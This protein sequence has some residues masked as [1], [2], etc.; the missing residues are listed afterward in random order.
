MATA[1]ATERITAKRAAQRERIIGAAL[2]AFSAR[3]FEATTT[4]QIADA[5]QMTGPALYHYFAA[6]DELLLACVTHLLDLLLAAL[7]QAAAGPGSPADRLAQ[8]VRVQIGLELRHG[9]AAPLVNAHLYGP[10]YLTDLLSPAQQTLLRDQQRALVQV[11]RGLID[12]GLACGQLA[13]AQPG[14]AAFNVLAVVQY[15]SVW[16]RPRAGRQRQDLIEQ[17]A[18]AVLQMLGCTAPPLPAARPPSRKGKP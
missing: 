13:T 3:G 2:Q 12:E 6:K 1:M 18:A 14:I 15:T 7:T 9:A 11:Y 10:R 5:L 4:A 16:Y 17:Q 8:A